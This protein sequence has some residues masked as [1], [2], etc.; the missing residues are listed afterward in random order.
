MSMRNVT[1]IK[2]RAVRATEA[3]DAP[4]IVYGLHREIRHSVGDMHISTYESPLLS[5]KEGQ[6]FDA[7]P[8]VGSAGQQAPSFNCA[9][10]PSAAGSLYPAQFEQDTV[11][12]VIFQTPKSFRER[13]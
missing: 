7:L 12:Y 11:W 9:T 3:T 2:T 1:S 4:L 10:L 8:G 5:E 6:I 13:S